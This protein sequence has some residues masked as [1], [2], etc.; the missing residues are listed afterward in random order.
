MKIII[1]KIIIIPVPLA[2]LGNALVMYGDCVAHTTKLS[3]RRA[4]QLWQIFIWLFP[5][6]ECGKLVWVIVMHARACA[7]RDLPMNQNVCVRSCDMIK[8]K[9]ISFNEIEFSNDAGIQARCAI[10]WTKQ[11]TIII[12]TCAIHT[13]VNWFQRSRYESSTTLCASDSW[14]RAHTH[15]HGKHFLFL[16]MLTG[17]MCHEQCVWITRLVYK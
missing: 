15:T 2:D 6:S 14:V 8:W 16:Q 5:Y 17:R 12:I 3:A 10:T 4:T 7:F 13:R 11:V 9:R 1:I